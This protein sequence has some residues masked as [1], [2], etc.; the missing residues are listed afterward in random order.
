MP[1]FESAC[2]LRECAA[3]ERPVEH[4]YFHS[5]DPML[6]CESCGGPTIK[7]ISTF[8]I[9]FTGEITRK[10]LDRESEGGNK[11]DGGHWVWEKRNTPDGKPKAK[12]ITT[13]QEQR[14]YARSEGVAVPSDLPKHFTPKEGGQGEANTCGMPGSWF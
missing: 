14:E 10:Y 1:I 8:G 2:I 4:F 3:A 13:W 6:P 5:S 7:L 11:A 9:V 12:Y